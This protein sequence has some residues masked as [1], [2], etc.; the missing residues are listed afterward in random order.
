MFCLRDNYG[1]VLPYFGDFAQM[2]IKT[3][4]LISIAH[5]NCQLMS[6]TIYIFQFNSWRQTILVGKWN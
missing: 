2:V 6:K 3:V 5:T 4:D 1:V